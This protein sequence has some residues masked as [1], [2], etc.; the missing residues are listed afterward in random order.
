MS[1]SLSAGELVAL[2]RRVFAPRADDRAIVVL[3]D[4]PDDVVADHEA[5]RVRREMAA[6]WASAL[7]GAEEETGLPASL[8]LYRNVHANNAELPDTAWRHAGGPLP[9]RA[10]ALDPAAAVPFAEVLA[11]GTLVIAPTELSATAPLKLAARERGLR[12]AT[13]P[14]FS[15]AMIP[16]LRLDYGEINRRVQILKALLDRA[17]AADLGFEVDGAAAHALRLDLRHRSAHASGGLLREPGVAGNVPSGEAY[18]VPYEGERPGDPSGTAGTLP[19]Q[20]G[21]EVVLY[22]IVRNRA[23]G[24]S[25]EG[26]AAQRER[27]RLAV[28]PAYGNLAELGL[29]V[30]ADFGLAPIG[31]TLL[32]EKLAPHVAFGRSDHFGGAVGPS[33]FSRPDAVVHIDRVYHPAL[34]PRVLIRKLTLRFDDGPAQPLV[35]E[36]RYVVDFDSG[37]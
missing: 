32:D 35:H 25:G 26:A 10:D 27:E 37:S 23:V 3:A 29:G 6:A 19:V 11:P 31:S 22:R 4:L 15:A 8:V 33:D 21:D 5:W 36:G 24:V 14:G 2:V 34:Q 30:L 12:A 20:L 16:A 18:I 1:E 7:A 28:E 9:T 13:M 17:V